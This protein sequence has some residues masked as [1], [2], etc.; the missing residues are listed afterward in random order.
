MWRIKVLYYNGK[1]LFAPYKR[2]RFLFF[3]FWE[4]AFLSEY[5]ELDVY[6]NHESYDSFF[7]GNCIGFYSEA[8]ARKYI[9]LYEEHCKLVAKTS[10]IKPEYIYPE[11]KP[12]GK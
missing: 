1:K 9:K 7:C 4:P 3:R 8:D 6:I 2:V 12:D 5:H 10:K 11:E